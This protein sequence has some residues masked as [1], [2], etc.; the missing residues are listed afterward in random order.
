MNQNVFLQGTTF[1]VG[2]QDKSVDYYEEMNKNLHDV[3]RHD[4]QTL[5][6]LQLQNYFRF[7]I[8]KMDGELHGMLKKLES[9]Q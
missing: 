6:S 9:H 1:H 2:I 4:F 7:L 8:C 3:H 5:V